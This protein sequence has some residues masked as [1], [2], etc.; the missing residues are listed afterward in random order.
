MHRILISA[1]AEND[2][3]SIVN[4]IS[5]ILQN[6]SAAI[7]HLDAI[8]KNITGLKEMPYRCPVVKDR[9][10]SGKNIRSLNVKNYQIFY[11]I[12]PATY[13]VTIIRVLYA[14]SSWEKLLDI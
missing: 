4:Y 6:P 3:K 9:Y 7:A 8:E 1:P 10:L 12:E 14:R 11:R 2:I 13:T 5:E